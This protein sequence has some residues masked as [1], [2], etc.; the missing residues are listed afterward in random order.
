WSP[1]ST[2]DS[3]GPAVYDPSPTSTTSTVWEPSL[4]IDG[5]GK[6]VAYF[7]DERQ[8]SSGVLQAVSYRR[9]TDGGATWG[10]LGNVSAP[11]NQ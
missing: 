5:G 8:K 9:S 4:A 11:P 2:I 6:L 10:A 1:L 7:S 3:G